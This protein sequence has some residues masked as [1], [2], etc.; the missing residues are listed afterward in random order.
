MWLYGDRTLF[1][2]TESAIEPWRL[3]TKKSSDTGT[4]S[5]ILGN[6]RLHAKRESLSSAENCAQNASQH[7]FGTCLRCEAGC[8]MRF[9]GTSQHQ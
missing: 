5:G 1:Q 9:G 3:K 7:L 4:Q 6:H 8:S 2:H